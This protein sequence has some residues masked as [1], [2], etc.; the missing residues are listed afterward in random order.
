MS[1]KKEDH[2][3]ETQ[4]LRR[5]VARVQVGDAILV[6]FTSMD[7]FGAAKGQPD[8]YELPI[9]HCPNVHPGE[10][11]RVRVLAIAKRARPL[12]IHGK[13]MELLEAHPDRREVQCQRHEQLGG[14]C[15]GCPL[16]SLSE[17]AQATAKATR[18]QG[19]LDLRIDGFE[20]SKSEYGY[21]WSAKRI[22][23]GR[24]GELILGSFVRGTH[25]V[26]DMEGCLVDHPLLV[27]AFTELR[28]QADAL[29]ITSW[30]RPQDGELR[31]AWAKTNGES[32]LL[33]L[34]GAAHAQDRLKE[35]AYALQRS[36]GVY[37]GVRDLEGNAMR[38]GR[39]DETL[40]H[41]RGKEGLTFSDAGVNETLGPLGFLQPNPELAGRAYD[42][43]ISDAEGKSLS[44]KLAFDLYAGA[45]LTTARLRGHFEAVRP[46]ESFGESAR[47]LGVE[48]E[49]V[50]DFLKDYTG[51][52][53]ELVV[54]NPPRAGLGAETC[55][56]LLRLAPARLHI[57]SCSPDSFARDLARLSPGFELEG[58]RL[59]DTLP[60]TAHVEL[61][62]W[63]RATSA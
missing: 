6:N 2:P 39:E 26:A 42:A 47:N 59:F 54:A 20:A 25:R 31:Y 51:D 49:T 3:G 14:R 36:A 44:G 10:R 23:G 30:R 16:M 35:L 33:T 12:R 1:S 18:I 29:E 8:G 34:L 19:D 32:V 9:V 13:L 41:V 27:E 22:V 24:R 15:G 62:A 60:Q 43:L 55:E 53:P 46:V 63:L 17:D 11:A 48:A 37:V 61:V 7:S 5:R 4:D 57:M 38:N 21:R 52:T 28:E 45:G 58:V 40:V 56:G 50:A